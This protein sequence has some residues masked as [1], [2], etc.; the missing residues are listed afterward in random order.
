MKHS[1]KRILA[2]ILPVML[3]LALFAG[4]G[5]KKD[6]GPANL[7][8]PENGDQIAVLHT[9]YGDITVQFFEDIAPK[10][11]E[12]FVTH[13]KDGYYD[14]LIFHRVINNF[15]IQTGDPTGTGNGGESIWGDPFGWE[16][17]DNAYNLRGALCMANKSADNTNGSQFY[18]VQAGVVDETTF[19]IYESYGYSFTDKQKELYGQYGGAPWLDGAYTV[20]GQVIDGMDVVDEIAAV[21]VNNDDRPL[22][23]VILESVE[24]TSYSKPE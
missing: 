4:C 13:S 21:K 23:D 12:N 17:S 24:I 3:I 6:D 22:E 20:F 11:V 7:R 8:T 1:L 18:I 2:L 16:L 10:A 15:M 14:D 19:S 9:S 5:G